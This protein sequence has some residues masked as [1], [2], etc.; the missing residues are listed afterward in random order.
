M[1][2]WSTPTHPPDP[3]DSR[4]HLHTRPAGLYER[5]S[6]QGRHHRD[7]ENGCRRRRDHQGVCACVRAR[8][9]VSVCV[10]GWVGGWV[11]GGCFAHTHTHYHPYAQLMAAQAAKLKAVE[12]DADADANVMDKNKAV[13]NTGVSARAC[14]RVCVCLCAC[15]HLYLNLKSWAWVYD[16][17]SYAS[18]VDR[19]TARPEPFNVWTNSGFP[20][21]AGRNRAFIR[22]AWKSPQTEQEL[23]SR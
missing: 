4:M 21:P 12:E 19:P 3:P 22:R 8:E 10:C 7:Q 20:P 9:C 6:R 14:V 17:G 16:C 15:A 5:G 11:G 13:G 1:G 18:H 23:I 2:L